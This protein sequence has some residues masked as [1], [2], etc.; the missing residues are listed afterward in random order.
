MAEHSY[1][2]VV[3]LGN[4]AAGAAKTSEEKAQDMVAKPQDDSKPSMLGAAVAYKS[5]KGFADQTVSFTVSNIAL[6]TGNSE[7]QA[8]AQF[9]LNTAN[10]AIMLG[11]AIATG[12]IL[13]AALMAVN[14][15]TSI[16]FKQAQIN[17]ENNIERES[18]AISR[19]RAGVAFNRSR[20]N[21]TG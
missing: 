17:L 7:S 1:E 2:I 21:G 11:G 10:E 16:A 20:M 4:N 5:I 6:T 8:R 14:K 15:I 3:R 19:Q 18:L 13:A 9:A 12:N